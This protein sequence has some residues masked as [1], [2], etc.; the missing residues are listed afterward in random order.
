M[1]PHRPALQIGE[2]RFEFAP[3]ALFNW[4]AFHL[5]WG[6]SCAREKRVHWRSGGRTD[7]MALRAPIIEL[8]RSTLNLHAQFFVLSTSFFALQ[9]SSL[10][11]VLQ[12]AMARSEPPDYNGSTTPEARMDVADSFPTFAKLQLSISR[13]SSRDDVQ[14][15]GAAAPYRSSS[16]LWNFHLSLPWRQVARCDCGNHLWP[17]SFPALAPITSRPLFKLAASPA[18]PPCK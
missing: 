15:S 14:G 16:L 8:S 17:F 10:S 5:S 6:V 13:T 3:C 7:G 11:F 4:P 18:S 12:T 1:H 2:I 9:S